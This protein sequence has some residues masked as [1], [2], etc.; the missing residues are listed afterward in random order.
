MGC[1]AY[2]RYSSDSP[3]KCC[4]WNGTLTHLA[5]IRRKIAIYFGII[6]FILFFLHVIPLVKKQSNLTKGLIVVF[7]AISLSSEILFQGFHIMFLTLIVAS[8]QINADNTEC[9]MSNN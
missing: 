8:I 2:T 1:L 6:G 9:Y 4:T 7:I 5:T 3:S